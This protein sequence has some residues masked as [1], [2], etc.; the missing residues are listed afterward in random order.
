[1]KN[2][3]LIVAAHPDDEVLGCFGTAARLIQ[4]G[5]EVYTL[6]LGEGK[7]SRKDQRQ[8]AK[9][10]K[11]FA[12]LEQECIKANELIGVKE[13][14][15]TKFADNRFDSINLLD[16]IKEVE[17]I[18]NKIKPN[19]IFTHYEKDLNIDHQLCFKAVL[20]ASRSLIGECVKEIYSFEVLSSTEF[21]Y[22]LSFSPNVYF[23]ISQTLELK[24]EA[25]NIYKSELC[26]FPH[27]R[28]LENIKHN[29]KYHGIRMGVKYA[30]AFIAIRILK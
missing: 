10:E 3:I 7:T 23:D 11:D 15:R 19:I 21:N 28:S 8:L 25:M 22:P 20:T 16:I 13:L 1:M 29:A 2:K 27:Q 24:L 17:K 26:D 12:I 14:F 5:S 30:E 4:E 18:K 9:H 6:V